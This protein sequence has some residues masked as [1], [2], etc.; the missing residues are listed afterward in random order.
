MRS[1]GWAIGWTLGAAVVAVAALLLLELI[2]RGR[3]IARQARDIERAL[4]GAREHTDALFELAETNAK[5]E[6]LARMQRGEATR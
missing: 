1:R 5:L 3:R 4:N 6:R 2:F